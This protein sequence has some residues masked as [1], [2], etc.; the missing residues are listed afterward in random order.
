MKW[1]H[2]WWYD[3]IHILL[4]T[5][6]RSGF[7]SARMQVWTDTNICPPS[8]D[9][10]YLTY[11]III[12]LHCKRTLIIFHWWKYFCR[13]LC[14]LMFYSESSSVHIISIFIYSLHI[15]CRIQRGASD[16]AGSDRTGTAIPVRWQTDR[17]EW[18]LYKRILLS[19]EFITTRYEVRTYQTN[20]LSC[21]SSWWTCTLAAGQR[22][23]VRRM[24]VRTATRSCWKTTWLSWGNATSS[25]KVSSLS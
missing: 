16:P 24:L 2:G 5:R 8:F 12:Y 20:P 15:S 7:R 18:W 25:P 14:H 10:K 23:R 13:N 11:G 1:I 9:P 6:N 17:G 3:S 19:V 21:R 4:E 22:R